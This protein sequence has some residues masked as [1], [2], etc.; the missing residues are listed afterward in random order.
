MSLTGLFAH[1]SGRVISLSRL[2]LSVSFA[3]VIW[4]DPSQPRGPETISYLLL[5]GYI[6]WSA[7]V[8]GLTWFSWR[9]DYRLADLAHVIDVGAFGVVVFLTEGYTSPFYAFFVFLLL[10]SSIRWSWRETAL[11]SLAIL[12]LFVSAGSAAMML[13]SEP[14]ELTR[15]L[16]RCLYLV[17]LSGLFIWFGINQAEA[18]PAPAAYP[19]APRRPGDQ[20]IADLLAVASARLSAPR[21]VFAW[22][23]DE[24]PWLHVMVRDQDHVRRERF[25]PDFFGNLLSDEAEHRVLLF[26]DRRGIG[27]RRRQDDPNR[28]VEFPQR[29]DPEFAAL[30]GIEDGLVIPIDAEDC[31]GLLFVAGRRSLSIDDIAIAERLGAQLSNMLDQSAALAVSEEEA[32]RRAKSSLARDLHDGVIQSLTGAS[33]KLAA[34]QTGLDEGEDVRGE[35]DTLREDLTAEQRQVRVFAE[36]LR[37]GPGP[38]RRVDLS[39]GLP[40]IS[41]EV[42]RRWNLVCEVKE[43]PAVEGP[44]WM[45][46][47]LHQMVREAAANAVRHGGATRIEIEMDNKDE[48]IGLCITDNGRGYAPTAS[49]TPSET[50]DAG[51]R[52]I[53]E[54]AQG[55]GGRVEFE[56]APE[57]C[58]TRIWLPAHDSR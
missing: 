1:R 27:L 50:G 29:I 18:E 7:L 46:H 23:A 49:E 38:M 6:L 40:Y 52:S 45:E 17:I 15:V 33:L 47:D 34:I 42:S 35:L 36:S 2:V 21:L 16:L 22:S 19:K 9:W 39:S 28:Y 31:A 30:F 58:R 32:V 4:L 20:P 3:A 5:F 25:A 44:V 24:E 54:R 8:L 51:P 48:G 12:I 10:S 55:I 53:R 41:E 14:G 11:T 56:S 37:S 13:G 26:D 43:M 57:S